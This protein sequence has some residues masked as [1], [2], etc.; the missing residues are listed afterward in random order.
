MTDLITV[1]VSAFGGVSAFPIRVALDRGDFQRYGLAVSLGTTSSSGEL[2]EGLLDGSLAVAHAA[3]DNVIAWSDRSGRA[4]DAW[5]AGSN[6]PIS[7]VARDAQGIGDLVG[8][9]IG[10]DAPT[11]GFAPILHRMLR[12]A[13]LSNDDV[14]LVEVGATRL[15]AVALGDWDID[16]T[17]LTLPW[18]ERAVRDGASILADHRTVAP[19]L[20]TSCAASPRDWLVGRPDVA[21]AYRA[22][23]AD[24]MAWI[25][26]PG[27]RAAVAA[28]LAGH[29]G[30]DEPMADSILDT[31][32]G[33]SGW[34]PDGIVDPAAMAAVGDLR[35]EVIAPPLRAP[36]SYVFALPS[37]V[38]PRARR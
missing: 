22:A 2:A 33:P 8:R 37:V 18:T 11:S 27:T 24:A 12:R 13:G 25:V 15:R 21:A 20:L 30:V 38:P 26:A 16:A 5:L 28:A 4:I 14:R 32:S 34:P 6:G 7:L 3:P 10:I 23:I 31:M 29:L 9:R 17:M 35:A 36:G 19:G 1:P